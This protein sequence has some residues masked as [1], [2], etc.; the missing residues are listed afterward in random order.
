MLLVVQ[1]KY[2][3][4]LRG[5]PLLMIYPKP[6]DFLEMSDLIALAESQSFSENENYDKISKLHPSPGD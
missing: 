6:I 2:F 5:F 4:V 3:I 1:S